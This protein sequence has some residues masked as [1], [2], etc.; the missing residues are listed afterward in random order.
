[1]NLDD[2]KPLMQLLKVTQALSA[3]DFTQEVSIDAEG[4]I[5]QLA[6]EV[7]QVVRNMRTAILTFSQTTNQAGNFAYAAQS[8]GDLMSNST[9]TVLDNTDEII[10]SCEKIEQI[11][12]SKEVLQEIKNIKVFALDIMSAQSYQDNAR[13]KLEKLEVDLCK[14][15]DAMIDAM[16]IMNVN[17][18][19]DSDHSMN[20]EEMLKEKQEML[21]AAQ[22]KNEEQK[23]D[24][25]NELLAEFGL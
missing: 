9:K 22:V 24:L 14:I 17:T 20:K 21:E 23:Q 13:Q 19:S 25:V 3:G 12:Q 6:G 8:I 5:A 18:K 10:N 2:K 16:I 7:N 1:M 11:E 15:R 4:L